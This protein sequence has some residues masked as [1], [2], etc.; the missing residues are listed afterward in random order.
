[1]NERDQNNG[2]LSDKSAKDMDQRLLGEE[3][4]V[5]T[6]KNHGAVM[7]VVDL[8]SFT[9]I[10]A[11]DAALKF[12]GYNRETMLTKRIPDLNV[13]PEI[14]I[15]KEIETA[16]AE[17]RSY[18]VFKHQLSCGELRDVEIY[19][20]P[21]TIK[22]IDY[23]FSIVHD[24]TERLLAE[25]AVRDNEE[26]YRN[27]FENA[28]DGVT[29]IDSNGYVVDCNII[30]QLLIGLNQ[31]EILGK[32]I[33]IFLSNE[34]KVLFLDAFYS[35]G[36][37]GVIELE[38]TVINKDGDVIPVWRKAT[39]VYD[40][41]GYF[42]GAIIHTRDITEYKKMESKLKHL[43][44]FDYLT[45]IPNRQLFNENL[46]YA[47]AQAK[48]QNNR[49]AL[50]FIDLDEFKKINDSYGHDIGDLLLKAFATRVKQHIRESDCIGRI[51]G[52]EFLVLLSNIE[53]VDN[54]MDLAKQICSVVEQPF[55]IPN[56]PG[57]KISSSI[58]VALYPDHA[59]THT[60]LMK[61]ADNAMYRVK[62]DG[63]NAVKF[64]QISSL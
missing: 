20:N 13:T 26:K 25:A 30:D 5:K 55:D 17:G 57:L 7:Y 6:F 58:G 8:L 56:Y 54:A 46:K 51:G 59:S 64:S 15:R 35:L 43:A 61:L 42:S 16:I 3:A 39:A 40:N 50:L 34:S 63:R 37:T 53:N 4:F 18:Y 52:D 11:N 32:H 48:R 23:S 36:K 49:L 44:E 9:I 22:G 31:D 45:Q 24:I 1:M 27:L 12:Y 14:E 41:K 10:D 60:Q 21:I 2:R 47:I 62:E 38:S 33:S 29:A 28:P 19:A